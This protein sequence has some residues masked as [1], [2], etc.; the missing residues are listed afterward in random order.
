MEYDTLNALTTSLG[1]ERSSLHDLEQVAAA[2]L[3]S[4][5]PN[6]KTPMHRGGSGDGA[7]EQDSIRTIDPD[8]HD[9]HNGLNISVSFDVSSADDASPG[10]DSADTIVPTAASPGQLAGTQPV[11]CL[12]S[13]ARAYCNAVGHN[14]LGGTTAFDVPCPRR[15]LTAVAP[16]QL[17]SFVRSPQHA[18]ACHTLHYGFNRFGAIVLRLRCVLQNGKAGRGRRAPGSSRG[19]AAGAAAAGAAAAGAAA[20]AG[21][22]ALDRIAEPENDSGLLGYGYRGAAYSNLAELRSILEQKTTALQRELDDEYVSQRRHIAGKLDSDLAGLRDELESKHG[23]ICAA[24]L[25]E[26]A[27]RIHGENA[28]ALE[29]ISA[30]FQ[31]RCS[32]ASSPLRTAVAVVVS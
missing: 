7:V 10:F 11:R 23:A 8:F 28:A 9:N 16:S 13:R 26:E 22:S 2:D 21:G 18:C 27:Q 17:R 24:L 25:R 30:Q 3:D 31:V 1:Q 29:E 20:A 4:L 12:C 32:A 5:R 14:C 15:F 6:S 19:A